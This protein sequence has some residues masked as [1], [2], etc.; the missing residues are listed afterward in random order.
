M[1]YE[2]QSGVTFQSELVID[3]FPD[4]G[5]LEE[6]LVTTARR[7]ERSIESLT[8]QFV[9]DDELLVLNRQYLDHDTYTDILTFPYSYD[10]IQSDICISIDRVRDNA[11]GQNCERLHELLRVI[12]H[13]LLHMC[14]HSDETPEDKESM[15]RLEDHY[16]ALWE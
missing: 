14:G 8:Y 6:W 5:K 7:E 12:V 9:S 1:I 11:R 13:G 3:E 16:L 2:G 10:P 4:P 15:R